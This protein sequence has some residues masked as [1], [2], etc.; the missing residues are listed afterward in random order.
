M[1][2]RL[3]LVVANA[4]LVGDPAELEIGVRDGRI[5]A[6]GPKVAGGAAAVLDAGG[7]LVLPAFVDAFVRLD[8]VETAGGQAVGTWDE[9][10]EADRQHKR[11]RPISAIVGAAEGWLRRAVAAGTGTARAAVDVDRIAGLEPLRALLEVKKAWAHAIDVQVVAVPSEGLQDSRARDLLGEAMRLGADVVGGCPHRDPAPDEH[12]QQVLAL[13]RRLARPV[14]LE[15]DP[16]LPAGTIA[17]QATML[18]RLL[19]ALEA[20][21]G[22]GQPITARHLCALGAVEAEGAGGLI[23]RIARAELAVSVVPG[24]DL[25][26]GGRADEKAARRG[27]APVRALRKAGV[28]LG[29]GSGGEDDLYAPLGTADVA[30]SAWLLAYAGYMGAPSDIPGLFAIATGGGARALGLADRGGIAPGMLADLVV[31]DEADPVE[32]FLG[33]APAR[34]VLHRGRIVA[35]TDV[36]REAHL[37]RAA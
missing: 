3:D 23:E 4:R 17:P 33:H 16:V 29:C 10:R 25:H 6:V 1:N 22:I 18:A 27:L 7:R 5:V 19:D 12:L 21:G 14:D 34:W 36:V 24:Q 20:G 26:F 28:P 32:A 15:L 35:T 2:D 31:L 9:A 11:G 13:A 30:R 8:K 37:P